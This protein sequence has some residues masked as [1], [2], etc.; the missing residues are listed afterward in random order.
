MKSAQIVGLSISF[1]SSKTLR[2]SLWCGVVWCDLEALCSSWLCNRTKLAC[3]LS[4]KA[5]Y[6][7]K[8]ANE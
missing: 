2:L 5:L 1:S 7:K 8:L 3:I 4:T 6:D